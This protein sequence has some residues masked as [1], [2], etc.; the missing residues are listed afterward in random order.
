[1]IV[2]LYAVF[3]LTLQLVLPVCVGGFEWHVINLIGERT[4]LA[5]HLIKNGRSQ[6]VK[7]GSQY[8][9]CVPSR[10]VPTG[11]HYFLQ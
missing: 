8:I 6:H 10:R 7:A 9:L 5:R 11:S 3:L 2:Q 4:K 1:M